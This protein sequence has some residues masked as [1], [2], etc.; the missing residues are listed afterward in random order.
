MQHITIRDNA[1]RGVVNKQVN[2]V[3]NTSINIAD[4]AKGVYFIRV[5]DSEGKIQT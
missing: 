2:N 5:K 1:G 4:L 3:D